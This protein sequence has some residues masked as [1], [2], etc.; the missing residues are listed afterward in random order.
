MAILPAARLQAPRSERPSAPP[1]P[2][3]RV[4]PRSLPAAAGSLLLLGVLVAALTVGGG[5]PVPVTAGLPDPGALTGWARPAVDLLVRLLAVLTVGQLAFVALLVPSSG[6]A[7]AGPDP[8]AVRAARWSTW[9]ALGWLGAE[10]ASLVLTASSLYGVPVTRLSAQG[11]LALLTQLSVG[12]ATL[13][14]GLLLG[15]VVIGLLL[16]GSV[17]RETVLLRADRAAAAWV[18]CARGLLLLALAAVV[19][20][21]VLAGHSAAAEDHAMAVGSLSVHVVSASL[22][23]GG[24]TGLLLHAR[25]A[26]DAATAVHR[27]S[28]LALGAVVLLATSGA[29]AAWLVAGTPTWAWTGEGWARLLLA[30]TALLLALAVVGWW[31]RRRTLPAL[32]AGRPRA[33]AR[34]GAAELVL[35]ALTLTVS[36]ALSVSPPPAPAADVPDVAL[37]TVPQAAAPAPAAADGVAADPGPGDGL[38]GP[39]APPAENGAADPAPVEV[40]APAGDMSGHDHGELSVSVLVDEERFHVSGTVRPGQ[41]VTVYNSGPSAVTITAL[42]GG[43]DVAV[44]S[45]TFTTFPAPA[46]VGEHPF[47][48]RS[49]GAPVDGDDVLLVSD[50]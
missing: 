31:H 28:V 48:S 43:F 7:A 11:V 4:R 8:A 30:K 37:V 50:D 25:G 45:R 2:R 24:L 35:M 20:P 10:A 32:R 13:W 27:F 1:P 39:L 40:P 49:P 33:F 22:W 26:P 18:W 15:A 19:V 44:P 42:D 34:L 23:A 29:V 3:G 21:V 36:V 14:V 6:T 5:R 12:R 17:L 16:L 38:A 46:E 47:R 9:S 41:P